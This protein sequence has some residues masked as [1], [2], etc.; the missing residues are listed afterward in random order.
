MNADTHPPPGVRVQPDILDDGVYV[1]PGLPTPSRP[2]ARVLVVDD[3]S[4]SRELIRFALSVRNC[5]VHEASSGTKG[6]ERALNEPFDLILL[7][8]VMPDMGGLSVL[9]EIRQTYSESERPVIVLSV[10]DASGD[11]AEAIHL[12][13]NDYLAKPIDVTQL[14]ARIEMQL[15]RK[16]AE[17]ALHTAHL[18]LEDQVSRR[19]S[20]LTQANADLVR[21]L[22]EHKNAER[23]LRESEGRYR[24]IYDHNPSMFFTID[25]SGVVVAVNDFGASQLGFTANELVG[26]PIAQ[27][28]PAS[29]EQTSAS[30]FDSC[31]HEPGQ[32]RRWETRMTRHDE[33]TLWVRACAK[34]IEDEGAARMLLVCEDI[35]ES[36]DL[37]VQ[38]AYQATHD[39][40]TG[41]VN[42]REF[43]SRLG[44]VLATAHNAGDEHA[45]C[46]LD[47]DQFK[48]VNDTCGHMAGDE[49]LRQLSSLLE[50][51]VR[52]RDTLARLG[53]DEF[54]VLMEHCGLEQAQRVAQ[55][56]LRTIAEF[57]YKWE[58]STF[59]IGVSIG[60]V[61]ITSHSDDV[62]AVM[63][64][65]DTACYV[66][67]DGGRNRVHVFRPD[68]EQL[69]RRHG[70]MQWVV[71]IQRALD[72]NRFML[73]YMPIQPLTN[74]HN[75]RG[76]KLGIIEGPHYELLLRMRDD[77]GGVIPPGAFLPAAERYN[78]SPQIDR[79]VVNSALEWLNANPSHLAELGS[80]AINL[81]GA[82]LSDDQFLVFLD[83][84][85]RTRRIPP[86]KI[87]F[88]LPESA[89]V[90]NLA[91]ATRFIKVLK[92]WGCRVSLD[93]FGSGL[94]SVAYLKSLPVDCLKIDGVFVKDIV[95]DPLDLAVVRSFT[96]I[97]R[98]T[99]KD[100]V[101]EFVESAG[102]MAK[103][104]ELGIDYAQGFGVARPRPLS[105]MC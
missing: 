27:R 58:E 88:E 15:K 10:I 75:P 41:L 89:A 82:I 29:E 3:R 20:A 5:D 91:S 83:R 37:S 68:D 2:T 1:G 32:L 45:L 90:A 48:V 51:H 97:G 61:P 67:K 101:A 66:A 47:L 100:I 6:L 102:I 86:H 7:D 55:T 79:W 57:R 17:D 103:V 87:A 43:E 50:Q 40:L 56:L 52:K 42:R 62:G 35:T 104:S 36:H 26:M 77:R 63:R 9:R 22:E 65:A 13:A 8:L 85:F 78:L 23:R 25:R 73:D 64:A 93:D 19:T 84:Q 49:L 11:V 60:V 53:G 72:E 54:A 21:E 46:Y 69:A 59:A 33:T 95:D 34:V 96:Q 12:G 38:L 98:V 4:S 31:W 18:S 70:E 39:P 80:C 94:A 28:Q 99:G 92:E 74:S 81:S 30:H 71:Q 24:A 14:S 44:R 76:R 16:R 105:E